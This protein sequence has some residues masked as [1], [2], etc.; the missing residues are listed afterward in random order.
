MASTLLLLALAASSAAPTATIVMGKAALD[1]DRLVRRDFKLRVRA[2]VLAHSRGLGRTMKKLGLAIA[3]FGQSA[4]PPLPDKTPLPDVPPAILVGATVCVLL[5]MAAVSWR[6]AMSSQPP[7][8]PGAPAALSYGGL[9]LTQPP[10]S[11]GALAALSYGGLDP[12]I[13]VAFRLLNTTGDG[14][15]TLPQLTEGSKTMWD[16]AAPALGEILGMKADRPGAPVSK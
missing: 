3:G 9:T 15:L 14:R 1:L 6:H 8:S 10:T 2:D 16:V 11:P 5:L 13:S 7:T 4:S 12:L